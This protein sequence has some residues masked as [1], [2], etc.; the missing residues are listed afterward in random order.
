MSRS[1]ANAM[2]LLGRV[3]DVL[4]PTAC[5]YCRSSS[6]VLPIPFFCSGC[7]SDFS[8]MTGP[9]CPRCGKSFESPKAFPQS[10]PLLQSCAGGT[11]P[12]FDQA[13]SIGYFEG[14]LREAIHQFKYR[15]CRSLGR[16]LG[17]WMA[18]QPKQLAAVDVV[19]PIPLHSAGSTFG[20]STRHCFLRTPS[21]PKF[22]VGL[23]LRQPVPDRVRPGRRW[24]FPERTGSEMLPVLF[25]LCRPEAVMRKN[26]LLID[27]VF[28][29]GATMNECARVLKL[30]GA[31]QVTALTLARVV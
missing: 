9:L 19:M 29:T 30:S 1:N 3:L 6:T 15:P 25:A 22:S 23:L 17:A 8:I 24:S 4:L 20:D 2:T 21:E 10:G 28:T 11:P 13:L 12:V 16:P 5:S 31:R 26:V 7:W 27:D 18:G 14:A